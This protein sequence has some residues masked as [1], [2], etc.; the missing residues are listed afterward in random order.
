MGA[1]EAMSAAVDD[2]A[3]EVVAAV[4]RS[5][6][7]FDRPLICIL[8]LPFDRVTVA[9]AVQRIRDAAFSGRRCFVSTPN[10]NFAMTA[11]A[12]A[13]F[14]DSVLRSDLSLIDGMPLVWIARLLGW[15]VR[16]RVSGAD[17]FEALQAHSGAP[18]NVYLFGG[19]PG[20]AAAACAAINR[21]GGG[22]EC[23]GY[24]EAGFGSVESMSDAAR[25]ARINRSG[26]H[27]VVVSLGA[28]KGQAWIEHNAARLAAPVL[29]H[30]GAVVNFAAGSVRRAPRWMQACGL[31]WLWRIGAEPGLWRRYAKDGLHALG[32]LLS[33]VLPDAIDSYRARR[34]RAGSTP[35]ARL[36]V[37]VTG[38][39][40]VLRFS[41]DWRS[42]TGLEA[43]RVALARA[44]QDHARVT[45]DLAGMS[46]I[47]GTLCALLLLARGWFE[48][49]GGWVVT[50][51]PAAVAA[52]LRRKLVMATLLG[53][54][55]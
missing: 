43:A 6:V 3:A 29:S 48:G 30:L 9:Q 20:A 49:R 37:T 52:A 35:A 25:I 21:R 33:R 39:G 24:D 34:I 4:P 41:G 13:A 5:R 45:V 53:A 27:F 15:P 44:A 22:V 46:A 54:E 23:V 2:L 51:P 11:R 14:R 50:G 36:D 10:L 32:L 55:R 7:A 1:H 8:G 40:H 18:V 17:V 38:H 31:E 12:D 47:G 16:E 19:P 26:A 28:R 42:E